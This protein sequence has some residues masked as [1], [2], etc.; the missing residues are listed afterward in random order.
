VTLTLASNG[1][2]TVADG[3]L[4]R[5][6]SGAGRLLTAS[7]AS[8]T[9][10]TY[11]YTT[12]AGKLRLSSI[13]GAST[14]ATLSYDGNGRLSGTQDAGSHAITYTYDSAG[15][16]STVTGPEGTTTNA[17][18]TDGRLSTLTAANG[19][20]ATFSYDTAG[21]VMSASKYA[22]GSSTAASTV[23]L[24]YGPGAGACDGTAGQTVVDHGGGA[25]TLWCWSA[26]GLAYD[27]SMLAGTDPKD[28]SEDADLASG[29]LGDGVAYVCN[30][31]TSCQ[32]DPDPD[33]SSL[34]APSFDGGGGVGI[35]SIPEGNDRWGLSDNNSPITFDS[36][37]NAVPAYNIF[38]VQHFKDLGIEYVRYIVRYDVATLAATDHDRRV[39]EAWLAAARNP[40]QPGG[41]KRVLVS[42][43]RCRGTHVVAGGGTVDCMNYLPSDTEYYAAITSFVGA[44]G[45]QVQDY[46]PWNEPDHKG[47]Q[48]TATIAPAGTAS[49]AINASNSGAYAAGY[50]WQLL[51]DACHNPALATPCNVAAGDFLDSDMADVTGTTT[52]YAKPYFDQ[53]VLGMGKRV[54]ASWAW[55]AYSDA[56]ATRNVPAGGTTALTRLRNF[57]KATV[58]TTSGISSPTVWMTEQGAVK[59][60]ISTSDGVDG[61]GHPVT[62]TKDNNHPQECQ[63]RIARLITGAPAISTR[64]K[65]FYY[66]QLTGAPPQDWGLLNGDSTA[67][68]AFK[69]YR[70]RT[71]SSYDYEQTFAGASCPAA[72]TTTTPKP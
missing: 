52:A 33:G 64:I 34:V 45:T 22:A 54:P 71:D 25:T 40:S 62:I 70:D 38:N 12:I 56:E 6:F 61:N 39:F 1:Q 3:D 41:A 35:F 19:E 36:S 47:Y 26:N 59:R 7:D 72:T 28:I 10:V 8:G 32:S 21:R 24:T 2:Y 42:F 51:N 20:Y 68:L 31:S 58:S 48:P 69:V 17:Y 15:R 46:T 60:V 43:E 16:L 14:S 23:T 5:V 63:A 11:N 13:Q 50:F 37:D 29:D 53:Y 49:T 27:A 18:G 67:R 65:R 30:N 44:Y 66:Y 9:S 55:H 57:L 4:H